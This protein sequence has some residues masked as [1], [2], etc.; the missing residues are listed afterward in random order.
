MSEFPHT[1]VSLGTKSLELALCAIWEYVLG[2]REI[3]PEDDFFALG[4]HSLAAMSLATEIEARLSAE[5]M[6]DEIATCPTPGSQARLLW[7]RVKVGAPRCLLPLRID[8]QRRQLFVVH[9][10]TGTLDCYQELARALN[11]Y[12]VS[13]LQARGVTNPVAPDLSIVEMASRYLSEIRTSQPAGPYLLLGYSFGAAVAA[14]IAHQLETK[15]E[16]VAI[17][18]FV[19]PPQ[20]PDGTARHEHDPAVAGSDGLCHVHRRA[21]SGYSWPRLGCEAHVVIAVDDSR[22]SSGDA[23]S[24]ISRQVEVCRT[25]GDH[26][27]MLD[28]RHV[29][30]VVNSIGPM[31]MRS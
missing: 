1:D 26:S 15:G 18:V 25:S 10:F 23:W 27:S 13:G 19:S 7:P 24:Y 8:E 2:T 20:P 17:A 21:L 4:G 12:P 11:G 29:N 31:L 9:P 14:E 3:S 6:L 16:R 22:S 5:L 30:S 28:A